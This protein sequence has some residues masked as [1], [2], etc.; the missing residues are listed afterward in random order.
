MKDNKRLKILLVI[1]CFLLVVL[2][3]MN[4]LFPQEET[5]TYGSLKG[6]EWQLEKP[7]ETLSLYSNNDFSYINNETGKTVT[8]FDKCTTYEI[9]KDNIILNCDKKIKIVTSGKNT[10][11]LKIDNNKKKFTQK[12]SNNYKIFKVGYLE[13]VNSPVLLT[14]YEDFIDYI[15]T[16]KNNYY[17]GEG[18]AVSSSTDA[19]KVQYDQDYFYENNLAIYYAPTNSGSI[20]IRNVRTIIKSDTLEAV[21]ELEIPEVGTMDMSGFMITIE[22]DKSIKHVK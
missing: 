22:T 8:G 2:V 7:K 18:N 15:S 6:T 10:I 12:E 9:E 5:F 13:N 16:F 17:D 11:T 21:Y 14:T 1:L 4:V 20:K 19:L 3:L